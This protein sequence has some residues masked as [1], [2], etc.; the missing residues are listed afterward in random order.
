M[1]QETERGTLQ[2]WFWRG[3]IVTVLFPVVYVLSIGPVVKLQMYGLFLPGAEYLYR[4][5]I[6]AMM[7][8]HRFESAMIWY[9]NVVWH[10]PMMNK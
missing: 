8:S 10:V 6:L 9:A 1:C 7:R 3:V 2:R 5:T 4:P